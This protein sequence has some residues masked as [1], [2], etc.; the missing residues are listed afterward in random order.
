MDDT[1]QQILESLKSILAE[2]RTKLVDLYKGK[3]I[4][5]YG[6]QFIIADVY[7]RISGIDKIEIN[8]IPEGEHFMLYFDEVKFVDIIKEVL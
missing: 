7:L 5:A 4:E 3:T 1:T 2:T 8:F 6:K